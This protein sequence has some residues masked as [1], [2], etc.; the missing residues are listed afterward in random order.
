MNKPTHIALLLAGGQGIRMHSSSPKQFMK[1]AGCPVILHTM[2]RLQQHPEIDHIYVVCHPDWKDFV[3]KT[4]LQGGIQKFAGTF[5]AGES[6]IDSLRNGIEGIRTKWDNENPIIMVHEAVRP[7]ISREIIS[8]NLRTFHTHGNAITAVKSNEAYMVSRDGTCSEESIP[9]ELLYRAQTPQT[10]Y[11]ND[12]EDT[13]R[14]ADKMNLGSSQSLY[15]LMREV[16]PKKE[17]FIA[18]GSELNF[19]LTLPE[20]IEILEAILSYRH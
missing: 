20:D 15:T 9:R 7:L 14:Q 2:D 4:A 16:F 8:N 11:L 19:K 5:E 10:F 18:P 12:L 1:V 17:L 13:F 6:S 3:V